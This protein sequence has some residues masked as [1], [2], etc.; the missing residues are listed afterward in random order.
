MG[1]RFVVF[2]EPTCSLDQDGVGRFIRLCRWLKQQ[3]AGV[4]II[5]HDGDII[6]ALADRVLML[7]GDGGHQLVDNERFFQDPQ[8]ASVVSS[9]TGNNSGPT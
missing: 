3:R 1:P 2:D 7:S 6:H 5:T 9:L 4:V 8:L